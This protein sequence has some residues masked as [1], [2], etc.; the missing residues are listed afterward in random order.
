MNW[1]RFT[2][3]YGQAVGYRATGPG[4][5]LWEVLPVNGRANRWEVRENGVWVGETFGSVEEA[6][7]WVS[8]S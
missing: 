6:Q 2:F 3:Y 7:V 8:G 5:K 4:E 1:E